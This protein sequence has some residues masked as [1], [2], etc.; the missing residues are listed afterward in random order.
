[1]EYK[2]LVD[3]VLES[4]NHVMLIGLRG[5]RALGLESGDIDLLIVVEE[6]EDN[7]NPLDYQVVSWEKFVSLYLNG[8]LETIECLN[9]IIYMDKP[10]E[11]DINLMASEN[12]QELY[13]DMIET[14]C[15]LVMKNQL[16]QIKRFPDKK[17]KFA[18]KSQLFY[19]ILHDDNPAALLWDSSSNVMDKHKENYL[20][21][22]ENPPENI[23]DI[24]NS[25]WDYRNDKSIKKVFIDNKNKS[26]NE[27]LKYFS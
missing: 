9:N 26:H 22:R 13:Y 21:F 25:L 27:I 17:V 23:D 5:G 11:D 1:M 20:E 4:Y 18:A 6:Y 2:T 16:K 10:I 15:Y 7:N 14:E 19:D 12:L 24:I 8:A 3:E